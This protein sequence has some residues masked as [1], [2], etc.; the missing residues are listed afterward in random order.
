MLMH[1]IPVIDFCLIGEAEYSFIAL[2]NALFDGGGAFHNLPHALYRENG[3]IHVTTRSQKPVQFESL[4]FP[5]RDHLERSLAPSGVN[6]ASIRI[7][8]SRGC[9]SACRYCVE[10]CVNL[11]QKGRTKAWI[12]KPLALFI[13]E[14][15]ML[16][17][18]YG[19][20]YFNINDS[21]FEDPGRRGIGRMLRFCSGIKKLGI[22]ASFKIHLRA[23]TLDRLDDKAFDLLKEAGVDIIVVGVESGLPAELDAYGKRATAEI[24][25][26]SIR[27]VDRDGRFFL[28]TGHMMFSPLLHLDDLPAKVAYLRKIGRGW[29]YLNLSNNLLVFYGTAFH[30]AIEMEGL[31]EKTPGEVRPVVPYRY[32]DP[33]VGKI[34][35][36]VSALRTSIP[37]VISLQNLLYDA[38]NMR[39]R[40]SN[41]SNGHLTLFASQFHE[42]EQVVNDVKEQ[43]QDIYKCYW[44]DCYAAVTRGLTIPDA[45]YIAPDI[46]GLYDRLCEGERKILTSLHVSGLNTD[47]LHLKTWLSVINTA[48]NTSWGRI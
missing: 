23:E 42:Y 44:D 27:R 43:L 19:A 39:A 35:N 21:S 13:D 12:E 3:K 9:I 37:E 24:I 40:F 32:R 7:Q 4:P 31:V 36:A 11:P 25:Q 10:S 41:P 18:R 20:Y 45:E 1:Q 2:C 29:D 46:A 16:S 28:L 8:S 17:E 26:R 5:S 38:C 33:R 6:S 15:K 34:S 14:I 47:R 48:K 30:R 22:A